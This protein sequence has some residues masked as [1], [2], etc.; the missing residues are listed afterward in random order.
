M[1]PP[2]DRRELDPRRAREARAQPAAVARAPAGPPTTTAGTGGVVRGRRRRRRRGAR[3][4]VAARG[5]VDRGAGVARSSTGPAGGTGAG[6]NPRYDPACRGAGARAEGRRAG[7]STARSA[8]RRGTARRRAT[9]DAARP[10]RSPRPSSPR[11][12]ATG[13]GAG[14][15]RAETV[16]AARRTAA[17]TGA[18]RAASATSAA[19]RDGDRRIGSSRGA[20]ATSRSPRAGRRARGAA[21]LPALLAVAGAA[22]RRARDRRRQP[23]DAAR[24]R[25]DGRVAGRAHPARSRRPELGRR[26][27][28]RAGARLTSFLTTSSHR[29]IGGSR[30]PVDRRHDPH[31]ASFLRVEH[32]GLRVTS[33]CSTRLYRMPMSLRLDADT[34]RLVRRLARSRGQTKSEVLREAVRALTREQSAPRSGPTLHDA[35]AHH[36]GCFDSGG[37]NLSA[38]TGR[39]FT[40]LLAERTRGRRSR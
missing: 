21:Q 28:H 30:G 2:G 18:G 7:R 19:E 9:A 40:A 15:Q 32:A 31:G 36:I 11:G 34:E 16:G 33:S 26:A 27:V 1:A 25:G 4:D 5:A 23:A 35:I 13:A 17:A 14:R 29:D 39:R 38:R 10:E 8:H 6:R 22:Q 3:A 20:G 12:R 24:G 37:M